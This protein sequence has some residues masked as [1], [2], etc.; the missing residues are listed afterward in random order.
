MTVTKVTAPRI[1]ETVSAEWREK[2][3]HLGCS[4]AS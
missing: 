2:I 3:V 1:E 4:W